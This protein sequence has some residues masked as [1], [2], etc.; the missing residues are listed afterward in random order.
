MS[1]LWLLGMVGTTYENIIP[2]ASTLNSSKQAYNIFDWAETNH[3]R[4]GFTLE[5]FY[6]VMTEVA[7]R[8]GMTLEAYIDYYNWCFA[9]PKEIPT[10]YN[11]SNYYISFTN[12]LNEAIRMYKEG[13]S[14]KEITDFTKVS[15][16]TLYKHFKLRG[17]ETRKPSLN[18]FDDR[19]R[20]AIQLY[21]DGVKL[22]EIYRKT[23]IHKKTLFSRIQ[24]L[25][26]PTRIPDR[27]TD[28]KDRIDLAVELYIKGETIARILAEARIGKRLLYE[29]I[30]KLGIPR[31]KTRG[32]SNG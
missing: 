32:K 15:E 18:T 8:N 2:L 12:R 10:D 5:R 28:N 1:S 26:I 14:K 11:G 7:K 25:G 19:L 24:K 3:N 22:E 13:A 17:I 20:T 31:R 27:S 30:D 6:K 23:Q 16:T 4:L 29:T 21:K 9:N